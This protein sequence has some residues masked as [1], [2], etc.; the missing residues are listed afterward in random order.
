[1]NE[2]HIVKEL[3]ESIKTYFVHDQAEK[4]AKKLKKPLNEK[5]KNFMK[6]M[7]ANVFTAGNVKATLKTQERTNLNEDKLLAKLNELGRSDCIVMKPSV[8]VEKVEDLIFKGE[9]DGKILQDCLEIKY[10]DTLT[11]KEVK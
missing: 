10:V 2:E 8:D 4:Q 7:K 3:E 6:T 1:M 11:V 9:L 5:I